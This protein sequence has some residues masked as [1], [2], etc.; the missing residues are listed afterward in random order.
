[1][2]AQAGSVNRISQDALVGL[3]GLSSTGALQYASEI[4]RMLSIAR[5]VVETGTITT[6]EEEA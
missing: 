4:T 1:L 5:S 3:T 2:L 6:A